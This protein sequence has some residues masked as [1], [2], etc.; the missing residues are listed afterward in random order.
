MDGY[1][2]SATEEPKI[3]LTGKWNESMHYQPCDVEGE[4]LPGTEL[5]EVSFKP[6]ITCRFSSCDRVLI[7][8]SYSIDCMCSKCTCWTPI[9]RKKKVIDTH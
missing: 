5:K 2:Y 9:Y 7:F 1:V 8:C 4:P 6:F 3:L